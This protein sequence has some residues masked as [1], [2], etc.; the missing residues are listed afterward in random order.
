MSAEH[1]TCIIDSILNT[2]P[3]FNGTHVV[4]GYALIQI[5]FM[6]VLWHR[7][8]NYLAIWLTSQ[9]PEIFCTM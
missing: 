3:D 7:V 1:D 8:D 4:I 6:Y 2:L 5:E 9:T